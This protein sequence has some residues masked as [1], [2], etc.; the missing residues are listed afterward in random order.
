[1]NVPTDKSAA[2]DE[3]VLGHSRR[4]LERLTSQA[5]L[6]E[7]I[8]RE[9]FSAA[10]IVSGMRVLEVGSGS[11]DVAFLCATLVGDQGSVVGIDRAPAAVAAARQRAEARSLR[12][13]S[14]LEGDPTGFAFDER[15]DAVVGRYVL[16][17]QADVARILRRLARCI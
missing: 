5:R 4:E 16:L 9:F 11:G 3:Y 8:T 12:N 10:G 2:F 13:V 6:I 15:F 14:F 17:F 1:M 7:P